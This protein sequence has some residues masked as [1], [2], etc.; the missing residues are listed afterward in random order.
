MKTTTK[1]LFLLIFF[2]AAIP[3]VLFSCERSSGEEELAGEIKSI[4]KQL[5]ARKLEMIES[6]KKQLK[7]EELTRLERA[8]LNEDNLDIVKNL[9]NKQLPYDKKNRGE[10]LARAIVF[11]S[12]SARVELLIQNDFGV[13]SRCLSGHALLKWATL[14]GNLDIIKLLITNDADVN[15]K[16]LDGYA[17]LGLSVFEL[18]LDTT[19]LLLENNAD[20]NSS[21]RNSK[22]GRCRSPLQIAEKIHSDNCA[23][24]RHLIL[25]RNLEGTRCSLVLGEMLKLL[26]AVSESESD[27]A[28]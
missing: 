25:Q 12:D 17:A 10:L 14:R 22:G 20:P 8:I 6:L 23:V 28:E 21:G 13:N 1:I 27:E 5:L 7:S 18:N 2:S 19:K 24:L 4:K 16:S 3:S 15:G 9:L 11:R 26:R